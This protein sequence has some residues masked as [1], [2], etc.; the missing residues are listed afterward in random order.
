MGLGKDKFAIGLLR[1]LSVPD[2]GKQK[3]KK[4]WAKSVAG[5][6]TLQWIIMFV[7]H[8]QHSQ[9]TNFGFSRRYDLWAA[10]CSAARASTGFSFSVVS[11]AATATST[12]G[13]KGPS[14]FTH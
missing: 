12:P 6:S 14:F 7:Q 1:L 3:K 8:E 11:N 13:M 10:E 5:S 2:F 9:C 4:A